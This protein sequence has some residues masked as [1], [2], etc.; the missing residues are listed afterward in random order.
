MN[1]DERRLELNGI[2]EQIIGCAFKVGNT[3]GVGF[4]EAV[5]E[6]A[7]VHELR[8]TS[9]LVEQQKILEVWYDGIVVG[10][11]RADLLVQKAI[12]VEL[13]AVT[14]LDSKNFAQC[15]NYLKASGLTLCLLINFGN[16][17]VEIKRVVRNF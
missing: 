17:K 4:L 6:N 2:T 8:K 7:L 16:P 13:K 5:Y 11:Y 10:N 14:A 9:L 15:M 1:T 12:I 3:L